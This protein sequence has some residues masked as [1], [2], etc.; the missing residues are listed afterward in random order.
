LL[1]SASQEDVTINGY[2]RSIR[3][4]K[5]RSFAVIGDGTSLDAVQA[6]LTPAQAQRYVAYMETNSELIVF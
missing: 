6:L 5:A 3:N 4:Q 1:E 2:I